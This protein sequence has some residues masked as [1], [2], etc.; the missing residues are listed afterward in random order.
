M[1]GGWRKRHRIRGARIKSG[2]PVGATGKEEASVFTTT[3][4]LGNRKDQVPKKVM[5]K[6]VAENKG[7]FF[8]NLIQDAVR[9][10]DYMSQAHPWQPRGYP[11]PI[12][13]DH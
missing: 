1:G 12:P 10:Q 7:T 6:P 13:E 2:G 8:Q 4:R 3:E 11:S 5:A 9:P